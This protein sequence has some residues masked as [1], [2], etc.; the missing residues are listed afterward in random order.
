MRDLE[1]VLSSLIPGVSVESILT[2]FQQRSQSVIAGPSN[3]PPDRTTSQ[4]VNDPVDQ[5]DSRNLVGSS[6]ESLPGR[7]DGFDWAEHEFSLGGL[8][9]GMAAL[10]IDPAGV[11]Y[12]G[13]SASRNYNIYVK[14]SH[15]CHSGKCSNPS[16]SP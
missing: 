9:D 3:P 13:M 4:F 14:N 5:V 15:R 10:S 7:A 16:T 12:L 1:A 6:I 2:S 8:A 11:G